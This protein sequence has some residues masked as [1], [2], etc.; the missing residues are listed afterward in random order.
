MNSQQ[1]STAYKGFFFQSM[2][3]IDEVPHISDGYNPAT[4]ML[5]ISTQA[6]EERLGK[7]FADVYKNSD[8]FRWR[9]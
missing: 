4:W 7:D 6:C 8:Q 1:Q 9:I 3:A 2:Q 5:E